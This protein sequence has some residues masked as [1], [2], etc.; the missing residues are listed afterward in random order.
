MSFPGCERA[1]PQ[2]ADTGG[3]HAVSFPGCERAGPQQAGTGDGKT[4][5]N[6]KAK[7]TETLNNLKANRVLQ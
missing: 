4:L 1:G 6:L 7:L 3:P 2:Q 5:N